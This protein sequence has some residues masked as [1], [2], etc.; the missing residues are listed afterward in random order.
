MLLKSLLRLWPFHSGKFSQADRAKL[1]L[2]RVEILEEE[3]LA[4]VTYRNFRGAGRVARWKRQ[5]FLAALALTPQRL[6]A[7]ANGRKVVDLGFDKAK[8][9]M[10]RFTLEDGD[11]LCIAIN[12]EDFH[13]NQRGTV[14]IRFQTMHAD[15]LY[16]RLKKVAMSLHSSP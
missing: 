14:E 3:V 8:T 7:T 4:S 13:P 6:L 12:A 1:E 10:A 5:W 2:E 16:H 11:R 15:L 9:G